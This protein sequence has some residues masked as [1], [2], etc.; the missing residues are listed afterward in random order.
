MIQ[1][2]A[3]ILSLLL[4]V[5]FIYLVQTPVSH[6]SLLAPIKTKEAKDSTQ[7]RLDQ[8]IEN[9][10]HYIQAHPEYNSEIAFFIDMHIPSYKNRF[11]VYNL[12]KKKI[13][14]KGL[15]AHGSG[16]ESGSDG[17]LVFSNT[18]NSL[19]T[20][21]GKYAVGY[22]YRGQFGKAYKLYGLDIT[23]D[24]AFKRHVVL[25]KYEQV[26][27]QEQETDICTSYGCPMVNEQF[28]KRLEKRIDQSDSPILMVIY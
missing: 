23:N 25:H 3:L 19:C 1:K 26:P 15:V 9:M 27:Y 5:A 17:R 6:K 13:L 2:I 22:S 18:E 14:D 8:Q 24:N 20:S 10:Q 21:L 11:W 16:S 12:K 4:C 7:F 28:F